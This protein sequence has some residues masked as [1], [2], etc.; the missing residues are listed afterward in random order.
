MPTT[1]TGTRPG[2]PK[3][4][5]I[6]TSGQSVDA[7]NV[8]PSPLPLTSLLSPVSSKVEMMFSED[9]GSLTVEQVQSTLLSTC[10]EFTF[11]SGQLKDGGKLLRRVED[12][13][14]RFPPL[15]SDMR[16]FQQKICINTYIE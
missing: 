9:T 7:A 15:N 8:N 12:I 16:P 4:L 1:T 2:S 5:Q 3:R 10:I 6:E 11:L 13:K 14:V